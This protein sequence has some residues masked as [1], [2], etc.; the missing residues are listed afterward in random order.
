MEHEDTWRVDL[1]DETSGLIDDGLARPGGGR[2]VGRKIGQAITATRLEASWK[3]S[4]F[5]E[6]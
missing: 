1:D 2:S 4:E 6:T 3:K 5:L